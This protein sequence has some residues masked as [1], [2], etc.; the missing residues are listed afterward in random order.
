MGAR[1]SRR[2]TGDLGPDESGPA[3]GMG[4]G[5]DLS[6]RRGAVGPPVG[7]AGG[8]DHGYPYGL[9]SVVRIG[10]ISDRVRPRREREQNGIHQ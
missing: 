4:P 9:R 5:A 10:R 8:P 6:A 3:R 1:P 7:H 2:K